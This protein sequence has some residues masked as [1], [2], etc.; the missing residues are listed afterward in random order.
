MATRAGV[1]RWTRVGIAGAGLVAIALGASLPPRGPVLLDVLSPAAGATVGLRGVELLVRLREPA[2]D[3]TLRVLLNGAD[4]TDL[5][6]T[7]ENGAYGRLFDLLPGPNLL[8]IEVSGR[9]PWAPARR[10]EQ[11]RELPLRMRP[12][13]DLDRG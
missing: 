3:G 4:V 10:F 12:P 5:L 1:R 2:I 7:G 11:V 8:R 9:V 6:M 13:I